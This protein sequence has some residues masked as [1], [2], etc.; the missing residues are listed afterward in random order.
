[1]S[2]IILLTAL[3][4]CLWGCIWLANI[5]G[6]LAPTPKWRTAVKV[7]IFIALLAS[8][9]V[10]EFIGKRQFEALCKANGIEGSDVS[11]ARGK[12]VKVE[13]GERTSQVGTIMP[14]KVEDVY[15]KDADTGELLIQHKNYIAAGGWLMRYTPISMG[16]P[17]P[18]LFDGSTCDVRVEQAIFKINSI[19]FLYK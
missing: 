19:T 11:K 18:M 4:V 15:F 17:Q 10:D 12:R 2:G 14:I 6:N 5:L 7:G 8:P 16:S 1:M 13:Y 3:A 9:F